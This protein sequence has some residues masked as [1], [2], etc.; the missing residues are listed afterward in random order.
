MTATKAGH[1]IV[2]AQ[3][4]GTH[5]RPLGSGDESQISGDGARV[6]ILSTTGLTDHCE[7]GPLRVVPSA[8][9]A[10]LAVPGNFCLRSLVWS[11]DSRRIAVVRVDSPTAE[12]LLTADPATGSVSAIATGIFDRPSFSP[13]ST[14]LAYVQYPDASRLRRGG[15]LRVIGLATHVIT[16]LRGRA[17]TP[18]WGPRTIAFANVVP[19]RVQGVVQGFANVALVRPDG[20]GFRLVTHRQA[21]RFGI[22]SGLTPIAWSGS[23]K[24][25]LGELRGQD[26]NF[27]Y[28]IDP[29]RA[30]ARLISR[31]VV[32]VALSR[33]GRTVYGRTPFDPASGGPHVL[34]VPWARGGKVRILVRHA[35]GPSFNVNAP[36]AK[37]SAAARLTAR[38]AAISATCSLQTAT[39]VLQALPGR[40]FNDPPADHVLCGP[41]TG[42]HSNAMVVS[43]ATP[44]CGGSIGWM[45]FKHVGGVWQTVFESHSGAFLDKLGSRFRETRFIL[46]PN[47]PHCFPTGGSKSRTWRWNGTRLVHRPFVRTG[48]MFF[49]PSRNLSCTIAIGSVRCSSQKAP[50]AGRLTARGGVATC[51]GTPCLTPATAYPTAAV[52][53]FGRSVTA[54][55]FTCMSRQTGVTCTVTRT[56][57]GFRIN[58]AGVTR[59]G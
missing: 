39:V 14:R 20:R 36:G 41:F 29:V 25:L 11:P 56:G 38:R 12:T 23:G 37:P 6:A 51:K 45:V 5:V 57:K 28:A 47:D 55:P 33:D 54:G 22:F 42:A 19:H 34:R 31:K 8:G 44:G 49:S 30:T 26:A 24:R 52:L 1:K 46:R 27:A 59:V 32:P 43:L 40:T 2:I 7:F 35:F 48:A 9:G 4:D 21:D 16:T 17:S 50:H 53:R 13:D 58:K 10:A 15:T 18:I 3:N